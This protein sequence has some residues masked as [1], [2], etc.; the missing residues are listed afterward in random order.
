[1]KNLVIDVGDFVKHVKNKCNVVEEEMEKL[2]ATEDELMCSISLAKMNNLGEEAERYVKEVLE[3]KQKIKFLEG[4]Q[5]ELKDL[6]LDLK[7]AIG[8][9]M[10]EN[11]DE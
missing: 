4:R 5:Q 2:K 7:L 6:T 11:K 10:T 9:H 8:N 3:L 1:M